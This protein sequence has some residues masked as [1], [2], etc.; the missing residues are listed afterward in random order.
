MA[1]VV[2]VD[3]ETLNADA[4]AF[5]LMAEGY[6]VYT[7]ADGRAGLD[8]I[9]RVR[10][11]LVITDFMMP[12]MTGL[13]MAQALNEST[14]GRTIPLI[15][16]TAAQAEVGRRHPELFDAVFEK[17]CFPEPILDTARV[18]LGRAGES[19]SE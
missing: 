2:V 13:E 3:D 8:L 18:L 15:L 10:P 16:L 5:L 19:S 17:P 6:E 14:Y 11:A 12:V 7:A 9:E 1:T 4:L